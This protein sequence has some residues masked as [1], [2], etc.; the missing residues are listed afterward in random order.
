MNGRTVLGVRI[1]GPP[2]HLQPVIDEF[3]EHGISTDRVVIGG[4][5]D[6]LAEET[7]RE[8]RRV[9]EQRQIPLDFVPELVGFGALESRTK[10]PRTA[11]IHLASSS[12]VSPYFKWKY[13]G[14]FAVAAVALV[15][16]AP[17]LALAAGLALVLWR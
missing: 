5:E 15:L 8:V 9:C 13:A 14:D 10:P 3:A 2:D 12:I 17:F 11:V 16:Y 6:L 4:G 7:L 1:L